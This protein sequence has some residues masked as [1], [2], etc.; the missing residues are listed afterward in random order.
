MLVDAL[1]LSKEN[2]LRC[3]HSANSQLPSML[4]TSV[5]VFRVSWMSFTRVP[6]IE[7]SCSR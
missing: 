7:V 2:R 5:A 4:N 1:T 6:I 3:S